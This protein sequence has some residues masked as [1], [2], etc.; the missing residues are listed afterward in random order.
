MKRKFIK[1]IVYGAGLLLTI[2]LTTYSVNAFS[3]AEIIVA[4]GCKY[5]G[6]A[7]DTCVFNNL[8]VYN[9]ISLESAT[10]CGYDPGT[11]EP[12]E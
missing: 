3:R 6:K 10:N 8:S 4:K 1:N 12:I 9:C 7:D 5:T 2:S 11:I